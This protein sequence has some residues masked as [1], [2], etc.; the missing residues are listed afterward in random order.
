MTPRIGSICTGYGGLDMAVHQVFGGELAWVADIDPGANQILAHRYPHLPNLGDITTVDWSQVEPVDIF[1]GGFP[2]QPVSAAGQRKGVTDDRWLFDD[3]CSALGRM[4]TRPRLLVFENVLGLLT[5]NRGDAMARVVQGLAA[6]GYVGSWR[7]VRA[8]DVGAPHRRERVFI[9]AEDANGAARG[10]WRVTAP[11]QAEGGRSRA[12]AGGRGGAPAA[13][14]AR[15]GHGN[16]GP[17]S[18]RGLSPAAVAG[19][20][21]DAACVGDQ[22]EPWSDPEVQF[23]SEL[24]TGDRADGGDRAAGADQHGG[25]AGVVAWGTYEPAIRRWEHVLGRPAPRP[26]EPG[27]TG[28][29]L[30][31]RFVEWMQ[32]LPAGW[33]TDVPGLARNAQLKALG[34]GVVPQQAALALRL[35]SARASR[36]GVAA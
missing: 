15:V 2:C 34:N 28:E 36:E 7:T 32:G 27:R 29:R 1:T 24:G 3:I 4:V 10:E 19:A 35:L 31:P 26:T 18:E 22:D 20:L 12:D 11:G 21:A 16:P 5:A 14:T 9:V 25:S 23:V 17:A 8:S 13:D 33:V 6:L 30:S